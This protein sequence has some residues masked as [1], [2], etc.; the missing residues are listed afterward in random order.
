MINGWLGDRIKPRNLLFCGIALSSVINLLFPFADLLTAEAV[1]PV[2]AVL[3]A[4]NGF[5]QA[6]MWPPIVKILVSA[7]DDAT[8]H[9]SVVRI[10][11]GSSFG[12][13]LVYLFAPLVISLVNWKWVFFSC[14]IFG[15][16]VTVLWGALKARVPCEISVASENSPVF[17]RDSFSHSALPKAVIFSLLLIGSAIVFQGMLR[18]GVTNWMPTYLA[19]VFDFNDTMSILC[20]LLLAVFSIPSFSVA[21]WLYRRFFKNEVFC[22]AMIFGVA[23]LAS[24]MMY[25]FF[26]GGWLMAIV[27]M[28]LIT[29]CMHGIN[30]MLI[31]HV[32]KRF[33][34]YGNISTLSGTINSCTYI[35][36]AIS[37]YGIA[38]LSERLGWQNTVGLWA[39]IG[40]LGLLCCLLASRPWRKMINQS[41]TEDF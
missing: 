15:A 19:E 26:G 16:A 8:Y 4:L 38:L 13:I 3:W 29:G 31:T 36:A 30:L 2:M 39:V 23:T 21:A 37:T 28:A 20:T 14:A 35:G 6:M 1:V 32:P 17:E 24:A 40:L 9:Y 12:T 7:T 27:A 22:A 5:A 25:L 41:I 10:S 18:D 34:K 11:W 33:K